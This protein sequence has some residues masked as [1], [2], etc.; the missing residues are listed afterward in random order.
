MKCLLAMAAIAL[1]APA[2]AWGVS[3]CLHYAGEP[4]TL[5]GQVVLKTF[6]GPPNFGESPATDARETQAILVLEKPLCVKANP[7]IFEEKEKN[8]MVIT[9]VPPAG[10][11]LGRY[12]G[13]KVRFLGT[14]F[15]AFTGHHR[16]PVLM[17]V[18]RAESLK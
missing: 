16:M 11:N 6:Y 18:I 17:Q 5:T 13:K 15:H 4:V 12:A 10:V 1:C 2:T 14:R 8:Q 7:G 9:L 3:E